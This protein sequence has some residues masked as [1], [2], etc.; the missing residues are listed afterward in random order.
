MRGALPFAAALA[1]LG[2]AGAIA[3]PVAIGGAGTSASSDRHEV[4]EIA[5]DWTPAHEAGFVLEPGGTVKV[6]TVEQWRALQVFPP[7]LQWWAAR[8]AVCESGF[9]PTASIIDIDGLPREGAWMVGATWH[10]P[11]PADL[12]GQARQVAAMVANHGT[13]IWSTSGGCAA[14]SR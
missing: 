9:D 14:W 1:A 7:D 13:R 2:L 3:R 8:T 11:V 5:H 4:I 12:D 6:L 10:G